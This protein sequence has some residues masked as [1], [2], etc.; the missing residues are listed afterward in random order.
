MALL[1]QA[2]AKHAV[3]INSIG[4]VYSWGDNT[5]GQLGVPVALTSSNVP[6]KVPTPAV[7]SVV[8][9]GDTHT[10]I[11]GNNNVIYAFGGVVT[12]SGQLGAGV[13]TGSDVPVAV[14]IPSKTISKLAAGTKHSVAL[15]TDG[16]VY[17]W[18]DNTNGQLGRTG[19]ANAPSAVTIGKT[20]SSI[21]ATG[22]VT[23]AIASDGSIYCWGDNSN[24]LVGD[25][26]IATT[27]TTPVA[28]NTTL[29]ASSLDIG[30]NNALLIS[31]GLLYSWGMIADVLSQEQS[32]V[33]SSPYYLNA[34]IL[35]G[36]TIACVSTGPQTTIAVDSSGN[37]YLW[38]QTTWTAVPAYTY[39]PTLIT[40]SGAVTSKKIVQ[41]S[42]GLDHYVFLTSDGSVF[43]VGANDV[44]Q[45]GIGSTVSSSVLTQVTLPSA[46]SAVQAGQKFTVVLLTNGNLFTFG[47]SQSIGV[48]GNNDNSNNAF[49]SPVQV[50]LNGKSASIIAA[51]T[52]HV[53]IATTDNLLYSWGSADNNVL[54]YAGA[55]PV[56]VPT[57]ITLSGKNISR[58]S[59]SSTHCL[60]LCSDNSVY[61]WGT[62]TY[63]QI[64]ADS[65]TATKITPTLITTATW[66]IT[67]I[68]AGNG[69]SLY[70]TRSGALYAVG[71]NDLGQLGL[72]STS[73]VSTLQLVS[74]TSS[75]TN[76][77]LP[78]QVYGDRSI[79]LVC[80][81][82]TCYGNQDNSASVCSGRGVCISQDVCICPS[83]YNSTNCATSTTPTPTPTPT[84]NNVCY[85]KT[86]SA[87]CSGH[88]TCNSNGLC[89]CSTN[90]RGLECS[91]TTCN[92]KNST[93]PTVCSSNG[94]CSAYNTCTC[95]YDTSGVDCASFSCYQTP[96]TDPTVC[97][98]KGTC[99][100][101]TT[102]VC[103]SGYGGT[104]CSDYNDPA[105][106]GDFMLFYLQPTV[107]SPNAAL[108]VVDITCSSN[109][110]TV[111]TTKGDGAKKTAANANAVVLFEP[112]L[113]TLYQYLDDSS[114]TGTS[115]GSGGTLVENLILVGL[116]QKFD[117]L[118]A[119]ASSETF[120]GMDFSAGYLSMWA[121][122]PT[123]QDVL[124][125]TDINDYTKP[126]EVKGAAIWS[127]YFDAVQLADII[128]V[129]LQPVGDTSSIVIMKFTVSPTDVSMDGLFKQTTQAGTGIMAYPFSTTV[130]KMY[131]Y[132]IAFVYTTQV[133][134]NVEIYKIEGGVAPKA[135]GAIKN[136]YTGPSQNV[137]NLSCDTPTEF[138]LFNNDRTKILR[139]NK[140]VAFD[141]TTSVKMTS[142]LPAKPAAYTS[143]T[144]VLLGKF[145]P[146]IP[147]QSSLYLTQYSVIPG[148]GSLRLFGNNLAISNASHAQLV[149]TGSNGGFV[150]SPNLVV[151]RCTDQEVTPT[152]IPT[153]GTSMPWYKYYCIT[154]PALPAGAG[155][156]QASVQVST[157]N[158]K[159]YT[160]IQGMSV[161]YYT[162]V[163]TSS[164]NTI[165]TYNDT[166]TV[167]GTYFVDSPLL[168][169]QF[170]L[171]N[172]T[173]VTGK[174]TSVGRFDAKEQVTCYVPKFDE[175]QHSLSGY[176]QVANDALTFLPY[177]SELVL[178]FTYQYPD[179]SPMFSS[180]DESSF[181]NKWVSGVLPAST[182]FDTSS[183]SFVSGSQMNLQS[184]FPASST[185]VRKAI[186]S[187]SNV[188]ANYKWA[189]V[190]FVIN[191]ATQGGVYTGNIAEIISFSDVQNYLYAALQIDSAA[192]KKNLFL[193]YIISGIPVS[194]PAQT[195]ACNF[196][197]GVKY[198]LAWGIVQ[199]AAGKWVMQGKLVAESQGNY[200][201]ASGIC[202]TQLSMPS[203]YS[204]WAWEDRT[205]SLGLGQSNSADEPVAKTSARKI[206]QNAQTSLSLTLDRAGFDCQVGLCGP[207]ADP[208]SP[209]YKAN[210]A[211]AKSALLSKT[212]MIIGAAVGGAAF[213][214]CCLI[215]IIICICCCFKKKKQ[216]V[217]IRKKKK[218]RVAPHDGPHQQQQ[219]Q[220]QAQGRGKG[221]NAPSPQRNQVVMPP[222]NP[223]IVQP[224]GGGA[225][226]QTRGGMARGAQRPLYA[227]PQR[228]LQTVQ[229]GPNRY[230]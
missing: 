2:G 21:Y 91:E 69:Y 190:S 199:D 128:L 161:V 209:T 225:P 150:K 76:F 88:G 163:I 172:G 181:S 70:L 230:R 30:V 71:Q 153:D 213:V 194:S 106:K 136:F 85:N 100:A 197:Y 220:R 108:E 17:T 41:A 20:I 155:S 192:S 123:I 133:N 15:T 145:A 82:P 159:T 16:V 94:V 52:R 60:V 148:G 43:T 158:D 119:S 166:I 167:K 97:S 98:G 110:Y 93:D 32:T 207:D 165:G 177:T 206:T 221:G 26:T 74:Q 83:T 57:Q 53:V 180:F 103:Q 87:A 89:T 195:V 38:G 46:A 118:F 222:R 228:E 9:A 211:A 4:E 178:P 179:Y 171:M 168:T 156:K 149:F 214:V 186:S 31:N 157:I 8:A 160:V 62:N 115:L 188:D 219:Q 143:S 42:A 1:V 35:N 116:S 19:S 48:L 86:G 126:A 134:S 202:N 170:T 196:D 80:T 11:L 7:A 201:T 141:I 229:R 6:V 12:Q 204:P 75:R 216:K 40:L 64:T 66:N 27:R 65:A 101:P 51:G 212:Q 34:T 95:N 58:L 39:T 205:F 25:A 92:G 36:K 10:L 175:T 215:C 45:L 198:V 68:A 137:P 79:A 224:R 131:S 154:S 90:Y 193:Y 56:L 164:S 47:G 49:S 127:T 5:E 185:K 147:T 104:G 14:T 121:I 63:S 23:C 55:S 218:T 81:R 125:V 28:V 99:T 142:T 67:N 182:A 176:V 152:P 54:G 120:Y 84:S 59:C 173:K 113:T 132:Y 191:N 210:A 122:T 77:N 226:Q 217:T 107:A 3:M 151:R 130:G 114:L 29:T 102:C 13:S 22:A 140:T 162:N 44:G 33:V 183:Y 24:G 109:Q 73:T 227:P 138:L 117:T 169:C 184:V 105:C 146:Q 139:F 124:S 144:R 189:Y 96:S 78:R 223:M 50:N 111:T 37:V 135:L 112:R 187:K 208:A 203:T 61:G 174:L 129:T 72:G 18:G 200:K